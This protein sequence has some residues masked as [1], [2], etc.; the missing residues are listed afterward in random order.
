MLLGQAYRKTNDLPIRIP[1]SPYWSVFKRFGRDEALALIVNVLGTGALG[2]LVAS[3]AVYTLLTLA[4]LDAE[5]VWA[6][7][8]VLALSVVGP[9]VEKVGFFI[10]HVWDAW[11]IYKT[12]REEDRQPLQ[13][14]LKRVVKGGMTSLIEDVLI[15]DPC[16]IA[17][18][19]LGQSFYPAAPVWLLAFVSFIVAVAF[20]PFVEWGLQE[21]VFNRHLAMARRH[22]FEMEPYYETRFHISKNVPPE[23][24]I[25]NMAKVFGLEIIEEPLHYSNLYFDCQLPEI[26]G[27]KAEFR[28]RWRT[29]TSRGKGMLKTAQI[30]WTRATEYRGAL[31]QH[32]YFP[33]R[34]LKLYATLKGTK[35]QNFDCISDQDVRWVAQ[36]V[37]DGECLGE[38]V[39]TR[40]IAR[41]QDLLVSADVSR[42]GAGYIVEIK[43]RDNVPLL[44]QA[45]RYLMRQYPVVQ[46]TE[47]KLGL[48]G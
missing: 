23:E 1:G 31:D 15:H 14:Y 12:T 21:L 19:W 46:T 17:L 24:L 32:R 7:W 41:S 38:V 11:G 5:A 18:M 9:V 30:V 2:W 34:K 37:S 26:S 10:G 13:H 43:T 4:G 3:G 33:I 44:I 6:S 25:A 28:L 16:Y 40:K 20:V 48:I 35:P 8:G 22:G 36:K 39:F 47:G 42:K 27:R 45:M 29:N